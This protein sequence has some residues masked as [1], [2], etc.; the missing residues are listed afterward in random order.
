[1]FKLW[2]G[3]MVVYML[4]PSDPGYDPNVKHGLVAALVDFP[5][6]TWSTVYR[7]TGAQDGAYGKGMSNSNKIVAAHG[8]GPEAAAVWLCKNYRGGGFSDWHL[9]SLEELKNLYWVKAPLKMQNQFYWTSSECAVFS[10]NNGLYN[11]YSAWYVDFS[12]GNQGNH[13]KDKVYYARAVRTF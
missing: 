13:L 9:P 12:T 8:L 6:C 5:S 1:M 10:G 7:N 11:W 4:Q 2:G 3:G